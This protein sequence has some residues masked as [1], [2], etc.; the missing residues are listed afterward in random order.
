MKKSIICCSFLITATCSFAQAPLSSNKKNPETT[1]ENKLEVTQEPIDSITVISTGKAISVEKV[2]LQKTEENK[3]PQ[4]MT[5]ST[6]KK[7]K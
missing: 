2:P 6:Q 1:T 3:S 7:P 5:I 4:P